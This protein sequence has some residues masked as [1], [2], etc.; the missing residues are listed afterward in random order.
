[1]GGGGD[2][3]KD[4]VHASEVGHAGSGSA[5]G[6]RTLRE[7]GRQSR[8]Q[9]AAHPLT[10]RCGVSL[11]SHPVEAEEAIEVNHDQPLQVWRPDYAS[12]TGSCRPLEQLTTHVR[13][14]SE[15]PPA[16][17]RTG[18]SLGNSGQASGVF[19]A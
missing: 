18:G 14:G 11:K 4:I 12:R 8:R 15:W 19:S 3:G 2:H 1:M 16:P 17:A 6:R 5:A 10:A 13:T 7:G 9:R